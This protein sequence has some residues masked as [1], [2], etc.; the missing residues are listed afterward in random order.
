MASTPK[1]LLDRIPLTQRSYLA[2]TIVT[3]A[4]RADQGIYTRS[5]CART[6]PT[7]TALCRPPAGRARAACGSSAHGAASALG[8]VVA[9]RR[10]GASHLQVAQLGDD[11]VHGG[12]DDVLGRQHARALHAKDER[13]LP[14]ALPALS[15]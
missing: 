6:V 5:G 7:S 2:F 12:R 1:G 4:W 11:D 14:R 13:V 9:A 8:A 10:A 15:G 3:L